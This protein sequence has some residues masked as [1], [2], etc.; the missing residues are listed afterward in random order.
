MALVPVEKCVIFDKIKDNLFLGDIEAAKDE[1]IIKSIDIVINVSNTEYVK[2]PDTTYIEYPID[3]HRSFQISNYFDEINEVIYTGIKN[4][5]NILIHCYN[6]V[7]RSVTILVAYLIS[8][9]L[10]LRESFEYVKSQRSSGYTRP[11]IGFF[12]QLI[13]YEKSLFG[14]NSMKVSDFCQL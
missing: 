2:Y 12:K 11:N 3:D 7:S 6:A 14:T 9:G 1:R 10:T 13:E 4:N 8:T 5:K